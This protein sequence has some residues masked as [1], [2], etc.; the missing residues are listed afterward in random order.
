MHDGQP[1]MHTVSLIR[2][3]FTHILMTAHAINIYPPPLAVEECKEREIARKI[4]MERE[5]EKE[6]EI[7]EK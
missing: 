7:Y 6:R 3:A 4:E 2:D 1:K 5:V